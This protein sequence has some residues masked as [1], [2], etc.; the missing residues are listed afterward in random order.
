MARAAAT[1]GVGLA[2]AL[3]AGALAA[4]GASKKACE[5]LAPSVRPGAIAFAPDG[6]S[7]WV[8]DGAKTTITQ[9][10]AKT[11]A[12]GRSIDV[13]GAP[14]DIAITPSGG[15]ALVLTAFYDRPSLVQVSLKSGKVLHRYDVGKEPAALA[16]SPDGRHVYVTSSG[17]AGSLTPIALRRHAVG[18]PTPLGTHAR[19]VAV[20][21]H[22]RTALVATY[23]DS[24]LAVVDL[25]THR[26]KAS[27]P[28]AAYPYDVA[29]SHDGRH[30]LVSHAGVGMRDLSLIDIARRRV[31]R[32]LRA[33]ADPGAVAFSRDGRT[34][35]AADYS[36]SSVAVIDVA[37]GKHRSVRVGARPHGI[38]VAPH[39]DRA[40][41]T[42][43]YS[44]AVHAVRLPKAR[45]A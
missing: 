40:L 34:A 26:V 19:G 32:K 38:A 18:R 22:G 23:G 27:I 42:S 28:T 25:R 31:V 39:A 4:D 36:A 13:G 17:K 43:E 20:D 21:S 15:R 35:L 2:E 12:R 3:P 8:A 1:A 44:G 45:H 11:L 9:I 6:R 29:I 14:I 7:A 5:P 30:A 16:L 10:S 37:T 41:V 24:S 33:G